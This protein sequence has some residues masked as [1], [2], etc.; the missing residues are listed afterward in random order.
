[1]SLASVWAVFLKRANGYVKI[2]SL[3]LL[4]NHVYLRKVGDNL[5]EHLCEAR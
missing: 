5:P 2:V 4:F 3:L 1:M